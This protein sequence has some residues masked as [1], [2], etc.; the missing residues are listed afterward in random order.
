MPIAVEPRSYTQVLDYLP[1][2]ATNK[3]SNSKLNHL[4]R[5]LNTVQGNVFAPEFRQFLSADNWKRAGQ[6]TF[7]TDISTGRSSSSFLI[8]RDNLVQFKDFMIPLFAICALWD[9]EV[10]RLMVLNN[11]KPTHEVNK[12][13][14]VDIAS[15]RRAETRTSSSGTCRSEYSR[16]TLTGSPRPW[17][18]SVKRACATRGPPPHA[19]K[20]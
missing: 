20:R 7:F 13:I 18:L 16:R 4:S 1:I 2:V 15:P 14:A 5:A 12:R 19:S 3:R 10:L 8:P 6:R 17:L 11:Q 9:P